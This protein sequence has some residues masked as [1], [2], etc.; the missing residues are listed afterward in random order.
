M[1]RRL[2]PHIQSKDRQAIFP[3]ITEDMAAY[4]IRVKQI[5]KGD[6]T[7]AELQ[8]GIVRE[9][10][11]PYCVALVER[12]GAG[13]QLAIYKAFIRQGF[14]PHAAEH[15]IL[16]L[17]YLAPQVLAK[18]SSLPQTK[19][20]FPQLY[21]CSLARKSLLQEYCQG[22]LIGT[23][24]YIDPQVLEESDIPTIIDV[25]DS[26]KSLPLESDVMRS[27][28]SDQLALTDIDV[29]AKYNFDLPNRA[30]KLSQ[31]LGQ[32]VVDCLNK[33]LR[34]LTNTHLFKNQS[35]QFTAHDIQPSNII[36]R[37]GQLCF[38][39]WERLCR[40]NNP[41]MD[42]TFF[43]ASLW[44]SPTLQSM[45]LQQVLQRH[46][47]QANFKEL[48]RHDF[49]FN[50]GTGELAYWIDRRSQEPDKPEIERAEAAIQAL[51]LQVKAA[52]AKQGQ[53]AD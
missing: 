53:W 23:L 31:A 2:H 48:I 42:Y 12:V 6:T 16:F 18:L 3:S 17:Q 28:V 15:E 29:I 30:A 36:K 33:V 24:R 11:D 39:D 45:Y 26:I 21:N 46:Q 9:S 34:D 52:L 27:L 50:R 35:M 43:Y 49:L 5:L 7:P 13:K 20:H 41:A 1:I 14:L 44:N 38:I 40:S 4:N 51:S 10:A 25:I 19:V 22:Q 32:P 37:N 8:Q 47:D